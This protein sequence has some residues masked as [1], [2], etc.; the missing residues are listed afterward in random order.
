MLIQICQQHAE[1]KR[2]SQM[3][4]SNFQTENANKANFGS[5]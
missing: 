3:T 2:M 4:I 5:F 1:F